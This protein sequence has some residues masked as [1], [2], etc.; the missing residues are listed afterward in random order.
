MLLFLRI[1]AGRFSC[2][3]CSPRERSFSAAPL[4]TAFH[5]TDPLVC[6]KASLASGRYWLDWWPHWPRT[7]ASYR[8]FFRLFRLRFWRSFFMHYWRW[9]CR[10]FHRIIVLRETAS[11]HHVG[12]PFA[13]RHPVITDCRH[14][15]RSWQCHT[16]QHPGNIQGSFTCH[17]ISFTDRS[18]LVRLNLIG[19]N[20]RHH[21]SPFSN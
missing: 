13:G 18:D 19:T 16:R 14:A 17:R 5:S 4:H 6:H 11:R 2:S 8:R 10:L 7:C 20:N 3:S 9:C 12:R 15:C 1:S 21:F